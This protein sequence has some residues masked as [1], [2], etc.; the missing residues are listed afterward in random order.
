[1][2]LSKKYKEELNK[3]VMDEDMK[4]RILHNVLSSNMEAKSTKILV[5]KKHNG[6]KRNMQVAAACFT[7]VASLSVIKSYPEFFKNKTSNIEKN[8]IIKDSVD[9]NKIFKNGEESEVNDNKGITNSNNDAPNHENVSPD[10]SN[11]KKYK[12]SEFVQSNKNLYDSENSP[13]I[14]QN[15]KNSDKSK[16]DS[17][18]S[19]NM[20]SAEQNSKGVSPGNSSVSSMPSMEPQTNINAEKSNSIGFGN[21]SKDVTINQDETASNNN[22]DNIPAVGVCGGFIKEY[23]TLEEAED[24]VKLKISPVKILPEGFKLSNISVISN[25]IIQI[26]YRNTQDDITFRAGKNV[27]N[28]SG[29]YNKYKIQNTSKVDGININL[30]GNKDKVINLATWEKDGVSYSISSIN[31]VDE[32]EML[33]MIID[34]QSKT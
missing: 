8:Q 3:I 30:E 26:E 21:N 11:D 31:G 23:K 34:T 15:N 9:E 4:K 7:V 16:V 28:I 17:S 33:N 1:M 25:E 24:A 10:I 13:Q 6:F 22:L 18:S 29:D 2:I 5:A 19:I 20:N 32:D 14:E 12:K 27:E